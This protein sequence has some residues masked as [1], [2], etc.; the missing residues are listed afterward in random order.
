MTPQAFD[1]IIAGSKFELPVNLK[2]RTEN[3][4]IQKLKI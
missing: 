1:V 3:K 4:I 2:Y